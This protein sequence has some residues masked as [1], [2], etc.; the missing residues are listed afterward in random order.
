MFKKKQASQHGK[1]GRGSV[2]D[3]EVRETVRRPDHTW[4]GSDGKLDSCS[5]YNTRAL[6]SYKQSEIIFTIKMISF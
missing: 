4:P 5:K 6:E 1:G 2:V 3:E